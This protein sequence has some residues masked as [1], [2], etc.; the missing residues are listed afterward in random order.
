MGIVIALALIV[1]FAAYH[2][3][4]FTRPVPPPLVLPRPQLPAHVPLVSFLVPA[5]NDGRHIPEFV[6]HYHQ[7]SYPHKELILCVGGQDGSWEIAKSLAAEDVQVTQ[8]KAGE[9]KQVALR[10][11]YPLA[12]GDIIYL[13]DIDCRLN[14]DTVNNL[15]DT[16][17]T[18][19]YSAVTG[20]SR[21]LDSQTDIPFVQVQWAIDQEVAPKTVSLTTGILGRNAAASRAALG[22]VGAFDEDVPAGTDY[23]L[24]KKLIKSEISIWYIPGYPMPSEYP[25]TVPIYIHKQARWIRN[26][27]VLGRQFHNQQE[28][29]SAFKTLMLPIITGLL[30]LGSLVL[31][32]MGATIF[33]PVATLALLVILQSYLNRELYLKHAKVHQSS[34]VVTILHWYADTVAALTAGWQILRKRLVW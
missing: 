3:Y 2:L 9:G 10:H 17:L 24:A 18:K 32:S 27:F 23:F 12:S 26:V 15:L 1:I 30:I 7:L 8:Q 21:P 5:W 19:G 22:A 33:W 28:V 29:Q 13:T 6:A 20:S 34:M 16:M 11:S 25:G 4:R 14:D 31:G